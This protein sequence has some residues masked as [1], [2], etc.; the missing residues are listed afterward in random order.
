MVDAWA[1][2]WANVRLLPNK[3]E[4]PAL[5]F[6]LRRIDFSGDVANQT[7]VFVGLAWTHWDTD[8]SFRMPD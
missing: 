2:L 5:A 1:G 3:I 8:T 7:E 6:G 4:F